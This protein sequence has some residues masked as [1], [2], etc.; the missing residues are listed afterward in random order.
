MVAHSSSIEE[1]EQSIGHFVFRSVTEKP[2]ILLSDA[3]SFQYPSACCSVIS[4]DNGEEELVVVE[5][6]K[7]EVGAI[8]AR[9]I[10]GGANPFDSIIPPEGG[11]GGPGGAEPN[12]IIAKCLC[13]CVCVCVCVGMDIYGVQNNFILTIQKIA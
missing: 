8:A 9:G 10:G 11:G 2:R 5:E 12:D 1:E 4:W 7:E 13:V 6:E 3:S